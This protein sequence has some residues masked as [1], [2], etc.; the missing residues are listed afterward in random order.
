METHVIEGFLFNAVD[1][2]GIAGCGSARPGFGCGLI[3]GHEAKCCRYVTLRE[4]ITMVR[5]PAVHLVG[6]GYDGS[7][8]ASRHNLHLAA[9]VVGEGEGGLGSEGSRELSVV[10]GHGEG[11]VVGAVADVVADGAEVVRRV[12]RGGDGQRGA[13]VDHEGVGGGVGRDYAGGKLHVMNA[14]GRSANDRNIL[15][16]KSTSFILQHHLSTYSYIAGE[17]PVDG[18]GHLFLARLG[19]GHVVVASK[20]T[21]DI[22]P[23]VYYFLVG[24]SGDVLCFTIDYEVVERRVPGGH[25][26]QRQRA[27][28]VGGEGQRGLGLEGGGEVDVGD[29]AVVGLLDGDVAVGVVVVVAEADEVV[30]GVGVGHDGDRGAVVYIICIRSAGSD[31]VGGDG[32]GG[33]VVLKIRRAVAIIIEFIKAATN[34]KGLSLFHTV[35]ELDYP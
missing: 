17:A 9:V 13:V 29:D 20:D 33:V 8:A 12:G 22:I 18:N 7:H 21:R 6:G 34:C 10:V 27:A 4:S 31:D 3:D 24:V 28:V 26:V 35:R 2:Q 25:A 23:E 30:L 15:R 1:Q 32:A 11:V 16:G 14:A 5:S 19:N